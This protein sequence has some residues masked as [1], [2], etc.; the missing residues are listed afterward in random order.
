MTEF[1]SPL[2][3]LHCLSQAFLCKAY[4]KR[5]G[6]SSTLLSLFIL[7]FHTVSSIFYVSTWSTWGNSKCNAIE[8]QKGRKLTLSVAPLHPDRLRA[9]RHL[10]A[11][12]Q[13][14][15]RGQIHLDGQTYWCNTNPRPSG[16]KYGLNSLLSVSRD[17]KAAAA[18]WA[19][20]TY[21]L[22]HTW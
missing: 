9:L 12:H 5:P 16:R 15:K 11:S 6:T 18:V 20:V 14:C 19:C 21:L 7:A 2:C 8:I 3:L 4:T 10:I 17:E 13:V 1:F 22:H